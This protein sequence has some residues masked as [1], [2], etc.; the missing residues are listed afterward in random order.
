[1]C[2]LNLETCPIG[3]HG[4]NKR[5]EDKDRR[6]SEKKEEKLV[7]AQNKIFSHQYEIH[8]LKNFFSHWH[9][10]DIRSF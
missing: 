5:M 1:M 6:E 4:Q 9:T 2:D 3:H 8:A 10:C 7:V